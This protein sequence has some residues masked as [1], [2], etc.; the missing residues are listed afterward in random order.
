MVRRSNQCTH[1]MQTTGCRVHDMS[2]YSIQSNPIIEIVNRNNSIKKRFV[3]DQMLNKSFDDNGIGSNRT[4]PKSDNIIYKFV[5]NIPKTNRTI[6]SM[7]CEWSFGWEICWIR[8]IKCKQKRKSK[9]VALIE[10]GECLIIDLCAVCVNKRV[11][12]ETIS[13]HSFRDQF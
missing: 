2:A 12:W 9:H 6:I 8:G 4:N 1:S 7:L 10:C 11:I 13:V 3:C 5:F